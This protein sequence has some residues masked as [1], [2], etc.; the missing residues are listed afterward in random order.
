MKPM[1]DTAFYPKDAF[2]LVKRYAEACGF[3]RNTENEVISILK[4]NK[5]IYLKEDE[6]YK[7]RDII[8]LLYTV[9]IRN[10]DFFDEKTLSIATD[11]KIKNLDKELIQKSSLGSFLPIKIDINKVNRKKENIMKKLKKDEF[12]GINERTLM[13]Q[14]L[15]RF[16][17]WVA[18]KR[19]ILI[20]GND[21]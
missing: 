19:I 20:G 14:A 11:C 3:S 7:L 4:R 6:K 12:F 9:G 13:Q 8:G 2:S 10:F 18:K 21:E 5:A 15:R 1:L 16:D 17:K